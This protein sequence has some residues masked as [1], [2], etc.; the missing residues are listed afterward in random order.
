MASGRR[1]AGV[2][3]DGSRAKA[4]VGHT[5]ALTD[6]GAMKLR[7]YKADALRCDEVADAAIGAIGVIGVIGAIGGLLCARELSSKVGGVVGG[8][9]H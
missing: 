3:S 6:A 4:C 2:E 8:P 1:H 9:P 5:D 7:P